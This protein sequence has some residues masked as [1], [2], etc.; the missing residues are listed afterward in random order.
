MT[1]A[2]RHSEI[3]ERPIPSILEDSDVASKPESIHNSKGYL[4]LVC[5]TPVVLRKSFIDFRIRISNG[6]SSILIEGI[7]FSLV[8][9]TAFSKNCYSQKAFSSEEGG[10]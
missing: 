10:D 8:L 7:P 6:C 1:I 3:A 5:L 9:K 2:K 4:L